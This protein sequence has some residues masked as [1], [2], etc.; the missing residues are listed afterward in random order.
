MKRPRLLCVDDDAG[1]RQFY[2]RLLGS[3]GFEVV[4]AGNAPQGLKV[5]HS[6]AGEIDAVIA[7]YDMPGMNGAELA[8]EL[9]RRNPGLPVIMVSGCQAVLEEA[10][11]FVD[12]SMPKGAP[13]DTIVEQ[14]ELLLTGQRHPAVPLSRYLPLGSALAGVA[15]AGFLIPKI[16]K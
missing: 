1:T 9:K 14:V 12:A 15:A 5:F 8:A 4:V 11:H 2:E 13:I 16:W 3:Y 7:D 10:P 6:D